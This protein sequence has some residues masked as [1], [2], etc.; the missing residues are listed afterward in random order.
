MINRLLHFKLLKILGVG[1][2][3]IVYEAHDTKA[4]K[5]VA[6]KTLS[7]IESFNTIQLKTEFRQIHH[8]IHP[9]LVGLYELFV[10]ESN[11]FYTMERIEGVSYF[12][13]V[14]Q[15]SCITKRMMKVEAS[16]HQLF[17]PFERLHAS[18]ITHGDIKPAN[19]KVTPKGRVVVFDFGFSQISNSKN[20]D[21]RTVGTWDYMAPELLWDSSSPHSD[22]YSLGILLYEAVTGELPF[23]GNAS[24]VLIKKQQNNYST[25]FFHSH[26]TPHW[27]TLL[28]Q[29]LLQGDRENRADS[30][31]IRQLLKT[32]FPHNTLY[33]NPFK[34]HTFF[35]RGVELDI[36]EKMFFRTLDGKC[37]FVSIEG[38]SG[39]GKSAL[40]EHFLQY[41]NRSH[42][43]I[44]LKSNP[45]LQ[46]HVAYNILDGIIDELVS[47]I[48][49]HE[50]YKQMIVPD[51]MF[52]LTQMFP[53][54]LSIQCFRNLDTS[55]KDIL[56]QDARKRGI[57]ALCVI[58]SQVSQILPVIL[59][60]DDIYSCDADSMRVFCEIISSSFLNNVSI[61]MTSQDFT[62]FDSEIESMNECILRNRNWKSEHI[63][64]GPLD[65]ESCKG[66]IKS[67]ISQELQ[68]SDNALE[69][70][71]HQAHG[72]PL[73]IIMLLYSNQSLSIAIE[74]D[75]MDDIFSHIFKSLD[76][77][78]KEIMSIVSIAKS[79][80][81]VDM[82]S[83]I[84][85]N[86]DDLRTILYRLKHT[87]QINISA[88]EHSIQ[89]SMHNDRLKDVVLQS[90]SSCVYSEINNRLASVLIDS[91][92]EYYDTI[93]SYLFLANQKDR[94]ATYAY[95][96]AQQAE[97]VFAF[98]KAAD[99]YQK[100]LEWKSGDGYH[101]IQYR[102]AWALF[103]GGYCTEAAPYFLEASH[104]LKEHEAYKSMSMAL[105]SY[106]SV[107]LLDDGINIAKK[108]LSNIGLTY[109][110]NNFTSV[111]SVMTNITKLCFYKNSKLL[112]DSKYETSQDRQSELFGL[113]GKGLIYTSPL[114]GLDFMLR[115]LHRSLHVNDNTNVALIL[116]YIGG[117]VFPN[118]SLFRLNAT[119]YLQ[120]VT[121][122]AVQKNDIYL[123]AMAS[124]WTAYSLLNKGDWQGLIDNSQ[125]GVSLLVNNCK[126]TTWERV[127]GAVAHCFGLCAQGDLKGYYA[128]ASKWRD[129]SI[130]KDDLY[131]AIFFSQYM[132]YCLIASD[133]CQE[134]RSLIK[135]MRSKWNYKEF[136]IPDFYTLRVV[137][138]CAL[139]EERYDDAL[140]EYVEYESSFKQI[141]GYRIAL[142]RLDILMIEARLS[143]SLKLRNKSHKKIRPIQ[144]IARILKRDK[145][146]D[147]QANAF[148]FY[149]CFYMMQS[150]R[151]RALVY[152]Y[153]AML[154]YRKIKMN[155][156]I[157]MVMKCQGIVMNQKV[158]VTEADSWM[159]NHGITNPDRWIAVMAPGFTTHKKSGESQ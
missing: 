127:I 110:K 75:I 77:I 155:I 80:I 66:I 20:L 91:R 130:Q 141:N 114:Q 69:K 90:I 25:Q 23:S 19:I 47:H 65:L 67:S 5:V 76:T 131:G 136:T 40:V 116:A 53:S 132:I 7:N 101:A 30:E 100:S 28:I 68:I 121:D 32:E 88:G 63:K 82:L 14:Q 150:D 26:E 124:I 138:L 157:Y 72:Y 142:S 22:W 70:I 149:A 13:Y 4:N 119:D 146:A 85:H 78:S 97:K 43:T 108:M 148:L 21:K 57:S 51:G 95:K 9:N 42:A 36:L 122:Y 102:L 118:I 18:G 8:I 144:K 10:D 93:A 12:E 45:T 83:Q 74:S 128:L 154:L 27:F 126:G 33:T 87:H 44:I 34:K 134:A 81:S 147:S 133:S 106:F 50:L 71:V 15:E 117:G 111:V 49:I 35:G 2:S 125:K 38:K 16:L 58:V 94:A 41:I 48:T 39:I 1:A 56:P 158:L 84:M 129:E 64:L 31:T 59:S 151:E 99:Y 105:Q 6:L 123:Q 73:F 115:S 86:K 159:K 24:E 37:S 143:L 139:Y 61:I 52:E 96:A 107:G 60:I 135:W 55:S 3:S 153:R 120:K 11:C 98:R 103:H 145:R 46:Q 140:S 112:T 113:I 29:Q 92:S 17:S 152:L 89:I 79:S 54:F 109:P 137:I 156:S 104:H 62:G